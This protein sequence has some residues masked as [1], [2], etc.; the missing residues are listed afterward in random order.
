MNDY[1]YLQEQT[2]QNKPVTRDIVL[3]FKVTVEI[4]KASVN[5]KLAFYSF[6]DFIK[7]VSGDIKGYGSGL[8]FNMETG[9][10]KE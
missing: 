1:N 2:K 6:E 8:I 7:R 5:D 9:V 4:D 10:I 3:E